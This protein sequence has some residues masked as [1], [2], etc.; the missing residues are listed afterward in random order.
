MRSGLQGLMAITVLAAASSAFAGSPP[1]AR[2][3]RSLA[4]VIEGREAGQP[5]DCLDIRRA[6]AVE[7][8]DKTALVYRM[9][10]GELYVNRPASG[11]EVLDREKLVTRRGVNTKLCR[12]DDLDLFFSSYGALSPRPIA[13]V[14][15]GAFVPYSKL[16]R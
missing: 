11:A 2:G 5:V 14:G 9:P 8:I 16:R 4:K 10:N 6:S 15:L 1:D 12:H 7:I 13:Y 3:E